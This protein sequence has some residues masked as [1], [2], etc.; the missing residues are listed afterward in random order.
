MFIRSVIKE[1]RAFM[2]FGLFLWLSTAFFLNHQARTNES[3]SLREQLAQSQ[4]MVLDRIQRLQMDLGLSLSEARDSGSQELK[5][6]RFESLAMVRMESRKFKVDQF[7]KL[8]AGLTQ[9]ELDQ[10]LESLGV[11][12]SADNS[13]VYLWVSG[14]SKRK[15]HLFSLLPFTLPSGEPA[16]GLG[17]SALPSDWLSFPSVKS[18]YIWDQLSQQMISA[19][20]GLHQGSELG[21]KFDQPSSSQLTGVQAVGDELLAWREIPDS[22]LI[23][24]L[25]KERVSLFSS[26]LIWSLLSLLF[27]ISAFMMSHKASDRLL[28]MNESKEDSQDDEREW[29]A[30][31]VLTK[32]S[33][34]SRVESQWEE[35][36]KENI[37]ENISEVQAF[38]APK[39]VE[40][41]S[42]FESVVEDQLLENFL[43]TKVKRANLLMDGVSE[44]LA[45][46]KME[47]QRDGV[48]VN[49]L[50]PEDLHSEWP[51]TQLRTVL[52][53]LI[54]NSLEA[55][56]SSETKTLTIS[57]QDL[58]D[59]IEMIVEDTGAGMT[60]E[61]YSRSLEAFFTTKPSVNKRRGLGLN[62]AKRLLDISNG[63]LRI[64][65]TP[66]VGTRVFLTFS[67]EAPLEKSEPTFKSEKGI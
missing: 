10:E 27:F 14:E 12:N 59:R 48:R 55:M 56:E 9:E 50:I 3:E 15:D 65:S 60:D 26:F 32:P 37:T 20:G 62:V 43:S 52:D 42:R 38:E 45:D 39:P 46:F 53:E 61:V 40:E 64:E 21:I 31:P 63:S 41:P 18:L 49:L 29:V 25:K 2:A 47:L 58:D 66:A 22:N 16:W 23:L 7:F 67:K 30:T 34:A 35:S 11:Q 33:Q 28:E 57:A 5:T 6:D 19:F 13:K 44:A 51:Q 8:K 4:S 17:V 54:K 36:P 1:R 24:V